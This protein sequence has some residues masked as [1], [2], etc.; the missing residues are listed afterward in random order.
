MRIYLTKGSKIMPPAQ[1]NEPLNGGCIGQVIESKSDK[2]RVGEYV[3][4]SFGWREY[5]VYNGADNNGKDIIIKVDPKI[6]PI[7]YFLG[8]LGYHWYHCICWASKNR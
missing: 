2:F 7:Q 8:I 6:A 5:W 1:L 3:K 4:A